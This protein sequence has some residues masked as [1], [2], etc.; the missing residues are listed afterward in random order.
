MDP[1]SKSRLRG[2]RRRAFVCCSRPSAGP[3]RTSR[4]KCNTFYRSKDQLFCFTSRRWRSSKFFCP[5]AQK[6]NEPAKAGFFALW[7]KRD[8]C[9]L[10]S[11][12]ALVQRSRRWARELG[13]NHG[14][15]QRGAGVRFG[16]QP[17]L[18]IQFERLSKF[19]RAEPLLDS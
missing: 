13:R 14:G 8:G 11:V 6:L 1:R 2:R 3:I 17:N 4:A 15:Q 18:A 7:R 5:G 12:V 10:S 19:D 16:D 9:W